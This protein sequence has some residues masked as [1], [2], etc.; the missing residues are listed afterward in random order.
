MHT[1]NWKHTFFIWANS[2]IFFSLKRQAVHFKFHYQIGQTFFD[3]SLFTAESL[4]VSPSRE[5]KIF[6]LP[7]PPHFAQPSVSEH[8]L[9]F[10][11]TCGWTNMYK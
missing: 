1:A 6:C 8:P 4:L 2:V 11:Q 10:T 7:P 5:L 3:P 9:S